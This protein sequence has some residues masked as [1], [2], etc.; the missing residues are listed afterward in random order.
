MKKR[1]LILSLVCSI[2]LIIALVT[3]T[4]VSVIPTSSQE[5]VQLPGTS[6][7]DP[8]GSNNDSQ[9]SDDVVYS[10]ESV[11]KGSEFDPY[12]IS[13]AEEFIYYISTYGGTLMP[14]YESL[15]QIVLN[16]LTI[17]ANDYS[18][19]EGKIFG[20]NREELSSDE[21]YVLRTSDGGL[22]YQR[23]GII[24]DNGNYSYTYSL[25][26]ITSASDLSKVLSNLYD[27]N[28]NKISSDEILYVYR[29]NGEVAYVGNLL[30]DGSYEVENAKD[31]NGNYIYRTISEELTEVVYFELVNDIDFTGYDYIP[32]FNNG[33][34]FIGVINGNGYTLSNIT[35]NVSVDNISNYT[36]ESESTITYNGKEIAIDVL[37]THIG[38]FGNTDGAV[39]SNLTI[40]SMTIV[41]ENDVYPYIKNGDFYID[42][43]NPLHEVTVG[44]VVAV[45]Y[46]TTIENVNVNAT[47]NADG[48]GLYSNGKVQGPNAVGGVVGYAYNTSVVGGTVN[49]SIIC[50]ADT[51]SF[52]VGGVMAYAR[53]S[54][55]ADVNANINVLATASIED[56]HVIYIGGLVGHMI[57]SNIENTNVSLTVNQTEAT[58]VDTGSV[59]VSD[60]DCNVVA[61]IV[62]SITDTDQDVKSTISNVMVGANVDMDCLYAGAVYEVNNNLDGEAVSLTDIIVA[63]EVN[64]L[65]ALGFAGNLYNVNIELNKSAID[66]ETGAEYN[67]KLTGYASLETT[68]DCVAVS[69]FAVNLTNTNLATNNL[70]DVKLIFSG[71]F[72]SQL[73]PV[74]T[75]RLSMKCFGSY[76]MV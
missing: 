57:S 58:R 51:I 44:S 52:F 34:S 28:Y 15:K 67:V 12:Y 21:V 36:Y 11:T 75:L 32:L 41:V 43:S 39:I 35:I 49:A 45:A 22:V 73:K 56:D 7:S 25:V 47:I 66:T 50:D 31:E 17:S 53:Y 2:C 8:S 33:D 9:N 64:V 63:S 38:L 54:E 48:Y 65:R 6:V 23:D 14:K 62:V 76:K 69:I 71:S 74:E 30:E 61:G 13:T 72:Y 60:S 19:F 10:N 16:E 26:E 70:E 42:N 37:S 18:N 1:N 55:I 3:L 24:Y 40:D 68:S 5:G 4:V 27:V 46:N 20:S 29:S 59:S